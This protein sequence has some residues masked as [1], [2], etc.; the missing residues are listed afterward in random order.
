MAATSVLPEQE[1]IASARSSSVVLLL[2]LEGLLVA[3][4]SATLYARTG[5]SWWLFAALILEMRQLR[6]VFAWNHNI[7]M[8][9]GREGLMRKLAAQ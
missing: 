8:S 1:R 7:V 6:P 4:I 2:R 5:V 9:W 3:V